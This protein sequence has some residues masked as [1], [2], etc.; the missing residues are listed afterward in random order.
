MTSN[1]WVGWIFT[2]L[3]TAV[4]AYTAIKTKL[5]GA[6]GKTPAGADGLRDMVTKLQGSVESMHRSVESGFGRVDGRID[7]LSARISWLEDEPADSEE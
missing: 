7:R 4:G 3:G 1:E 6:L 5:E 2:G